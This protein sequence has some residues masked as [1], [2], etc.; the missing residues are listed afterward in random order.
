MIAT[1]TDTGF[2]MGDVSHTAAR[3]FFTNLFHP[4]HTVML[5]FRS[6]GSSRSVWSVRQLWL[7]TLLQ[8]QQAKPSL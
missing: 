1:V 2:I 4:C 3:L 7:V 6:F 8:W 5:Y